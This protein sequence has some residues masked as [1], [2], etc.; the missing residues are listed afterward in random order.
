MRCP[1]DGTSLVLM[2]RAGVDIEYCPDCRGVWL[3]R[4][5]L[6]KIIDSSEPVHK[7]TAFQSAYG[8]N[9]RSNKGSFISSLFDF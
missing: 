1:A 6:D 8:S 2:D 9:I 4:D 3:D 7:R 5:E